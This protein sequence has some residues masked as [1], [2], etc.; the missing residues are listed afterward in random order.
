MLWANA[1][2]D[3]RIQGWRKTSLEKVGA[4]AVERDENGG[5]AKDV[6][7]VGQRFCYRFSLGAYMAGSCS[8]IC[9]VEYA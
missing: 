4:E 3:E 2:A 8:L 9:A 5:W 6:R 7:A 1:L